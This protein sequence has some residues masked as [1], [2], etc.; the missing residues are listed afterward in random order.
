MYVDNN[1]EAQDSIRYSCALLSNINQRNDIKKL[2]SFNAYV[3]DI[4][5]RATSD[6]FFDIRFKFLYDAVLSIASGNAT[7]T[8]VD[9]IDSFFYIYK[10]SYITREDT[11]RYLHA[12]LLDN[13]KFPFQDLSDFIQYCQDT[14][15]VLWHAMANIVAENTKLSAGDVKAIIDAGTAFAIVGAVYNYPFQQNKE[16][17]LFLFKP[18]N[19]IIEDNNHEAEVIE[20]IKSALKHAN[21]L[22]YRKSYNKYI[23]RM[24][25]LNNYT[26]Q[27]IN[28]F[29][30]IKHISDITNL[31]AKAGIRRTYVKHIISRIYK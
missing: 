22:L 14:G 26:K 8:Q 19:Y 20:N 25:I 29:S 17:H 28:Q 24:L 10:K 27:Y 15:G 13:S 9:A 1:I 5:H 11:I 21:N 3:A 23:Y 4:G 16:R 6:T 31:S 2:L 18:P 12:R 30:K 7:K